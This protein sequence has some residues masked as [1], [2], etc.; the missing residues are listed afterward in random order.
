MKTLLIV[1][2]IGIA[3]VASIITTYQKRSRPQNKNAE[4]KGKKPMTLET[5]LEVLKSC[6]LQLAVPFTIKDLL[7]AR[8]REEY[9][10]DDWEAVLLGLAT[11]EEDE[12]YR[13][14]SVNLWYFD[15]EC[16]EDNGDYKRIVERMVEMSQGSFKLEDIK[17]HVD[18]ESDV[19][20][21]SFKFKGKEMKFDL[22]VQDDWVDATIFGKFV[23]LLK[24]SDPS[25]L[26]IY[27]D[28]GG[29][30]C[31]IGCVTRS[32]FDCLR[33]KGMKFTPL[34]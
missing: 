24:E 31:I 4:Q 13:N 28:L 23:E 7:T 5:K 6:G 16:I 15:T 21:L 20:W 18:L 9:E 10:K 12:P 29:Q 19:A 22:K 14:Y 25:K 2:I 26:Y 32:E 8:D 17:D 1:A 27:Y 11:T 34:D 3:L 33:S 30:D